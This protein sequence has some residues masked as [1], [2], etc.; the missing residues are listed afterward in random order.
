MRP[1]IGGGALLMLGCWLAAAEPP[2]SG[3]L[4]EVSVRLPTRLDWEF[5]AGSI[6]PEETRLP[7]DYESARQRYQ[8]FVPPGYK[9]NRAWPL[10]VFLSPGDAPLGWHSWQKVCEDNDVFFCCA[11][12]AGNNVPP[13]RRIRIVLDM[14]DDVR[15]RYHISPEETYLAGF[16]GGAR[17]ACTLAFSLPEYFGGVAA[18]CGGSPPHGLDYLRHRARDR[19]SVAVVTGADDPDRR[20]C[21]VYLA[22]L[23]EDLEVRTRLWSVPKMGHEMP[24]ADVLGEVYTWLETDLL[25]RRQDVK[26]RPGLA[27]GADEVPTRKV[28]AERMLAAGRADILQ[29]DRVY[30]GV[31]LLLGVVAR[32][33]KTDAADQA[34]ELLRGVRD[35]PRRLERLAAQGGSEERKV[36]AAHARALDRFGQSQAALETWELL[37]KSHPGTPE[38]AKAAE[39]IRRLGALV[40]SSPYLGLQ[41]EG[42]TTVVH[43]VVPRG[44][45]ARA[46]VRRGDQVLKVGQTATV[47]LADLRSALRAVKPGDKLELEVRRA[48]ESVNLTVEVGTPPPPEKE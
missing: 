36:L 10:V 4:P 41:F 42:E 29:P 2:A 18:I 32:W 12:G 25:R 37:A 45:A 7:A 15:R 34:R 14:V 5:V 26:D 8:L 24:P 39:E 19:L 44:P 46:G 22:P 17:L 31:A 13:G 47:S 33:D 27:V 28:Q 11:Y 35:E 20:E 21:G 38:A 23:L 30:L 9:R 3:F 1:A 40:T 48:A 16:G 6:S 43:T